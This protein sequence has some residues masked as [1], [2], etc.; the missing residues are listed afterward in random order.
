M[1]NTL[2]NILEKAG[3]KTVVSYKNKDIRKS[4]DQSFEKTKMD[5][6]SS[7]IGSDSN[8]YALEKKASNI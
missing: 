5:L 4:F 6:V 1:K 3:K 7:F 8:A 2:K